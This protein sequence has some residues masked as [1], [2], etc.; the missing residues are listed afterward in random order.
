MPVS[1]PESWVYYLI[2]LFIEHDINLIGLALFCGLLV[3]P[4]L[5]PSFSSEMITFLKWSPSL[6]APFLRNGGADD[7]EI[8]NLWKCSYSY[9]EIIM[10]ANFTVF[11]RQYQPCF[12]KMALKQLQPKITIIQEKGSWGKNSVTCKREAMTAKVTREI[13]KGGQ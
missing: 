6:S 5:L 7:T 3:L 9:R 1:L 10:A 12:F 13:T 8:E 11:K 2:L 4:Q